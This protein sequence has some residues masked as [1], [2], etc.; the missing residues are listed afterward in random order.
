MYVAENILSSVADENNN[1]TTNFSNNSS[2]AISTLIPTQLN[3][4]R[5]NPNKMEWWRRRQL[6]IIMENEITRLAFSNRH[7]QRKIK[8][9]P[10]II[11]FWYFKLMIFAILNEIESNILLRL[12]SLRFTSKLCLGQIQV[13]ANC[14]ILF[15]KLKMIMMTR[16]FVVVSDWLIL[17]SSH[18]IIENENK[19]IHEWNYDK[20]EKIC[21][22]WWHRNSHR[23][24]Y[25]YMSLLLFGVI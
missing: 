16:F 13:H 10:T 3:G 24:A 25:T 22:R 12:I 9:D 1:C 21:L 23:I 8:S 6:I 7:H 17:P 11:A 2:F 20:I 15:L 5:R 14:Y 19:N 18:H 4:I